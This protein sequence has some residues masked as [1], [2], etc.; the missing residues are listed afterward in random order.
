MKRLLATRRRV[1]AVGALAAV[2]VAVA[3]SYGYAAITATNN[4]YTGCLQSGAITNLAIGTSP[5]KPCPNNSTQ[6]SWNQTGPQGASGAPG[7]QGPKGDT[8]A[9]GA[10]GQKGDPGAPGAQ[11]PK[12]DPGAPG[13]QGTKG[14]TGA[15]GPQ[16][17]PGTDGKDGKDG[18]SLIG[19]ACSL[20]DNT[21]G[22][23]Q[24]NV[25][26]D[27][28]ISF[29]CHTD[30]GSG[31][32]GTDLCANVP[33]YPHATTNC[34]PA[35]GTLSITCLPGFANAD[36]DIT[37]GCETDLN[38][39]VNN[40]G[41]V[42]NTVPSL[43]HAT[44][45]CVNGA[46]AIV[47][48]DVHFA[49]LDGNPANG[50]ED[51]LLTDVNNCGQVGRPAGS[52][53]PNA[54][55]VAAWGCASGAPVIEACQGENY[56]VNN[57]AA[58]GCERLQTL[59]AHTQAAAHDLGSLPCDDGTSSS[60]VAG[61][62]YSDSQSHTPPISAFDGV[63]GSAPAWYH[64]HAAGGAFCI[65]DYQVTFTT[66]GGSTASSCYRLTLQTNVR[67]DAVNVTGN[68]AATMVGGSGSYSDGS[69][70]FFKVEKTCALPV[71]DAIHYQIDFH[72]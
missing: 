4:T 65:N 55:A 36:G 29:T 46:Y 22:T 25:A 34:N 23:V 28:A 54:V 11:G 19:S 27:G 48:C 13:A 43:P 59:A 21:P 60:S 61:N 44:V 33:S 50:C 9:P 69:E 20:P 18:T 56:D 12:G 67:T 32:G 52:V 70:V 31:G 42:G 63:V 38:T 6:I 51:D 49:D 62:L 30:A 64:V 10:Q 14:D 15:T 37:N 2:L 40:C 24:M 53:F 17:I 66:S 71:Q 41:G 39:D 1:F 72:L 26:A 3:A 7:A 68:D 35:T 47:A 16:G 5:M 57:A 45:G 58:D 8:G